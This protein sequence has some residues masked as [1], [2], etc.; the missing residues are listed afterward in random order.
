MTNLDAIKKKQK[1]ESRKAV[2]ELFLEQQ[3]EMNL[4][5][6]RQITSHLHTIKNHLYETSLIDI[7]TW[8]EEASEVIEFFV[9]N[10]KEV[11]KVK[12]IYLPSIEKLFLIQ[13]ELSFYI[14]FKYEAK[15]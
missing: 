6:A 8:I 14:I 1:R 11:R 3:L 12:E 5:R 4:F 2:E 10:Q 15:F 13:N 7:K 9:N